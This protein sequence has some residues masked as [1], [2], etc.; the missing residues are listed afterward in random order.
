MAPNAPA[1]PAAPSGAKAA[2][3][4]KKKG[5][6]DEEPELSEEDAKLKADL[7][8][9]VER[10]TGNA[11]GADVRK[12]AL[13]MMR[14]SIASATSSMTAVP[15]PLKFLRPHYGA[16]KK[17]FLRTPESDALRAP[18]ADVMS[19]LAMTMAEEG[20]L[21]SLRF[22]LLGDKE[23]LGGW[24]HEYVR[25]LSGEVAAAYA[26]HSA[27]EKEAVKTEEKEADAD[28]L[29]PVSTGLISK[30]DLMHLVRQIVPFNM[31]HY[32]E[33]DAVDL[34]VEVEQ[35]EL[36]KEFV[37]E[38]S[39]GRACLYL[40]SMSAYL[41]E[42]DDTLCLAV[43][44]DIY[45]AY[46]VWDDALRLALRMNEPERM[47]A[48]FLACPDALGRKQL[49]HI[50]G[51]QGAALD[52]SEEEELDDDECETLAEAVG[53]ARLSETYL[54]LARDLDVMEAKTPEDIYKAHLIDGRQPTAATVDSARANLAATY[55]NAFVNAGFGS[56]KLMTAPPPES[57]SGSTVS[58]LYKNKDHGKIAA[59]ASLGAITL[60][61]VDGGL[62]QID[63]YLY[64]SD[65]HVVA[66]ALLAVGVVNTGVR[67]ECDPAFALLSDSVGNENADVRSCAIM[68][69]GLAYAGCCKEEVHELLCDT[70]N[71]DGLSMEAASMAAL[72]LGMVYVGSC[73]QEV[74][75]AI[76]EALM[77]RTSEEL[78]QPAARFM[79]L[80]LG[81]VFLNKQEAVEPSVEVAK[82]LDAAVS[83]L[84]VVTLE[85]CAYAGSGSV[86]RVQQLLHMCSEHLGA[87]AEEK[88]EGDDAAA[89]EG[90]EEEPIWHQAVACL[91][92]AM[93]ALGE[94]LGSAMSV[95]AL[96]HLLQ[97]GET[98]LR[99]AVPLSLALLSVSNPQ[100]TIADMLSRLTHDADAETAQGAIL[101]LGIISAGT[102]NARIAGMLRN[103][104]SYYYK[105]S[106]AL[107]MVR[108]AQGLCHA[109]KGLVTLSPYRSPSQLCPAAFAGL[110]VTLFA[111]LD[112]KATI[113]GKQH[114]LLYSLFS[115][116]APRM[117]VTVDE[118]GSP[119][120]VPVR[121]GQAV[122]VVGQAGKPKS[123]TG[124][125]T[126]TTPVL[127]GA[128]DRAELA[129]EKYI[130]LTSALEGIVILKPNPDYVEPEPG[131]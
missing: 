79:C 86:L 126:H 14:T 36:V 57:S 29:P 66:G 97:Y 96:E 88:A 76:C 106:A 125:Q 112:V 17:L 128:G 75:G 115:S 103:L 38:H 35:L 51:R 72:S 99:R 50:L 89:A 48:V 47:R 5:D 27:E 90:K 123:I 61:D 39:Y 124:F 69:L 55:V 19:V 122:D 1:A 94:E 22:K 54:A 53:N 32:A 104:S 40:A 31:E 58:W 116:M 37:T 78:A 114:Y 41:A 85:V 77:G 67:N 44:Y 111:A 105:D 84:C 64:S 49:A 80:G 119:L 4:K 109:G 11:E 20:T 93:V 2:D 56:D 42:P 33:P 34:L 7:E 107:F 120:P 28:A 10:L 13:D 110:L 100:M 25:N 59:A 82:V 63:K 60:W 52:L 26:Q 9:M 18:L 130:A 81:L 83:K 95:R 6:K 70:L 118:E 12:S 30:E 43:A 62:P 102:N 16:L 8:L 21:E 45:M 127:L 3:K 46:K 65:P 24:G 74:A 23:D 113:G 98:N 129:S 15:K 131:K 108:V 71:E 101:S 117:L 68:G 121:V 91:G 73:N 87:E 92:V